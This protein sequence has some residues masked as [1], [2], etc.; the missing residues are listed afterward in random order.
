MPDVDVAV[1]LAEENVLAD[2]VSVTVL[3]DVKR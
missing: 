1:V 3:D 2:L